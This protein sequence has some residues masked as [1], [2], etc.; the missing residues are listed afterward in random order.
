METRF[1]AIVIGGGHAGI[2]ASR[3]LSA[4]GFKT[5]LISFDAKKI[6]AMSC[7]PAIGGVAKSHLVYEVDALGGLMGW[8]ADHAAIQSR[9]LNLRKGPAVRS[10]RV[11][12][13]KSH[14]AACMSTWAAAR[15]NLYIIE[16]EAASFEWDKDSHKVS[17]VRMK[18]GSRL[19]ARAVII[20]SGTFMRGLMFC[21]DERSVGGRVGEKAAEFLSQS[22]ESVGHALTRLKTGTPARLKASSIRFALLARQ[23]GDA[24]KRPFSWRPAPYRLPQISCF[25]THTNERTHDVIRANFGSSPLFSGDIVGVGP[26][27]CPSVE[28][29]IRRFPDRE[30]HQIF[31]EPEGINTDSIYPNGMST[32]LPASV[33][34]EFLRTIDGLENVELLRPGYAVE[35]DTIDPTDLDIGFMSKHL[36]GLFLA[37]QVNRTSGYEEAAAQGLW[38][39]LNASLWLEGRDFISP[40]RSRSYLETLVDDLTSVGT[41]EPYRMFTSRSEYRLLLREDNAAERLF[42]LASSLGLISDEQKAAHDAVQRGVSSALISLGS[43]RVRLDRDRVVSLFEYLRRP[44]V[45]WEDLTLD[46]DSRWS[47]RVLEKIEVKAKYEGYLQKQEQEIEQLRRVR[48]WV[49]D[50]NVSLRGLAGL[51][52]EAVELFESHRPKTVYEL[53]RIAG[54]TP[55]ALLAIVRVAGRGPGDVSRETL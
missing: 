38:A 1:D 4:R 22:L 19:Q 5:A 42:D 18:D 20:T 34:I 43:Q 8:A 54:I 27:Y 47:D 21:G 33:Q 50:P 26:R 11:Q 29:K 2:E 16:G 25:I 44:D 52:N 6:G 23:W 40:D 55:A 15:E 37:G 49:L 45:A 14:Y 46:L 35:Y 28:D 12:C 41:R 24:E 39:G 31:L 51:T 32:S 9:R 7:N 36:P 17:G 48:S 53:G 10:T 30:R 3:A 13:D